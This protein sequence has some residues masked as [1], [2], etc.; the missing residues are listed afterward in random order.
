MNFPS[1]LVFPRGKLHEIRYVDN[2]LHLIE[3]TTRAAIGL[4]RSLACGP[5]FSRFW[6]CAEESRGREQ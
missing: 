6:A 1:R 5:W 3:G 2:F 4:G